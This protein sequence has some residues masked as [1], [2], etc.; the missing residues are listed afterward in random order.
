MEEVRV[1]CDGF[2]YFGLVVSRIYMLDG[3]V[4]VKFWFNFVCSFIYSVR[5]V[6]GF[7]RVWFVV[8]MLTG[9]FWVFFML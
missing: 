1:V 6:V 2:F 8:T 3:N 9:F 7:G 5:A 4:N